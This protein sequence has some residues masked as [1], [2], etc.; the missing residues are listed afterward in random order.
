MPDWAIA[1][2]AVVIGTVLGFF[3]NFWNSNRIEN[4]RRRQEAL[5]KHFEDIHTRVIQKLS[6]MARS[7]CISNNR[8][9]FG[10]IDTIKEKYDFEEEESYKGFEIHFPEISS[11]WIRLK[12]GALKESK[13]LENINIKSLQEKF[14][15]YA[16][17]LSATVINTQRYGIGT[18][19]KHNKKCPTCRKF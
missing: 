2:L 4:K 12:E 9:V 15:E 16:R 6:S 19:F 1:I 8:L 3:L 11:E 10:G 13:Q 7:L 14:G 18:T 5:E 17:K